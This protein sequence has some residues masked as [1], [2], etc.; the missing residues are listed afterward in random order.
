MGQPI[1]AGRN[2]VRGS[3]RW[4]ARQEGGEGEVVGSGGGVGNHEGFFMV[5][6][7]KLSW[8]EGV[9]GRRGRGTPG[10]W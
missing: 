8:Q 10:V 1:G 3:R 5:L 7:S 9:M 2:G 6:K 4:E